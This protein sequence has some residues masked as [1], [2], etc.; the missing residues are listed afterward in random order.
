MQSK[1]NTSV[2]EL[3]T[4]LG[5]GLLD[6][7]AALILG[8]VLE[9]LQLVEADLVLGF[10]DD[11]AAVVAGQMDDGLVAADLV[12]GAARVLA[13]VFGDEADDVERH[14]TEVVDGTEAV[15]DGDG[16]AALE[17]LDF[18]RGV[19]DRLQFALEVRVLAL[20]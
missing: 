18:E 16:P 19:S 12:D 3:D 4:D 15:A 6:H 9:V 20:A 13:R 17:P 14:V 2:S 8:L 7:L 10:G 5:A 11:L 1:V